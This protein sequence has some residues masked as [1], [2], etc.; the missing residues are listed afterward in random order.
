[1]ITPIW[2]QGL[3]AA[4]LR[5]IAFEVDTSSLKGGRRNVKHEFP[6][7]DIGVIE[8]LGRKLREAPIVGFVL[9]DDWQS[10]LNALISACEQGGPARLVHPVFGVMLVS[11]DSYEVTVSSDS[12]RH[13]QISLDLSESGELQFPTGASSTSA[14]LAASAAAAKDA[15]AGAFAAGF[16]TASRPGFVAAAAIGQISAQVATVRKSL[17]RAGSSALADPAAVATA[18]GELELQATALVATPSALAAQT[19]AVVEQLGVLGVLVKLAAGAGQATAGT[20]A[21]PTGQALLDNAAALSRLWTRAALIA[22][23]NIVASTTFASYDEAIATRDTLA[24]GLSAEAEGADDDTFEA[25]TS[26]R[27][28]LAE[29]IEQRAGE[30]VRLRSWAAPG[31]T[32]TLQAAQD[33][34]GDG[35]RESE[36]EA[37]NLPPHPGFIASDLIVATL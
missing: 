31:L 25:L 5:G 37:R 24:D 30:L 15:T 23:C 19:A 27:L 11:V 34:Y 4:S 18:L 32:S 36:I 3:Q 21:T 10:R 13:A 16:A 14:S 2:R 20:A 28:A 22:A 35:S 9:G 1:M 26:L 33:L 6:Q 8:D 12:G 7:R 17:L 29:D